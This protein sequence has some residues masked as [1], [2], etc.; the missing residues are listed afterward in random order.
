MTTAD[1]RSQTV[2]TAARTQD[3][4]LVAVNADAPSAGA[5]LW[6]CTEA[7]R[8]GLPLEIVVAVPDLPSGPTPSSIPA[9]LES[10]VDRLRHE[11]ELLPP[12]VRTGPPL[13]ILLDRANEHSRCLVLG[14]RDLGSV[15]RVIAGSMS[16]AVAGRSPVP[17]VV[18]PDRWVAVARGSHPVVA[19]VATTA[20]DSEIDGAVLR[21]AFE[22][23]DR[24]RVPL[25][26]THAWDVP[27]LLSWSPA[28]VE[29]SRARAE[30][31]L[32]VLLAPWR[33]EFAHVEVVARV[34]AGSPS[35]VLAE[36]AEV[37]QLVVVGR[38]TPAY[39]VGGFHLGSTARK[40]MHH[41][42]VPVLV[43]PVVD[44]AQRV[45]VPLGICAPMY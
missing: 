37:A 26:V 33:A 10:F 39:R 5:A 29:R 31:A 13:N 22:Q 27:A 17:V 6:A 28:D 4:I 18:V 23:A 3:R 38:H 1:T 19:G 43:V 15:Y 42:D 36:A 21:A 35:D 34:V 40:F 20:V 41:L 44:R 30:Q 32:D 24:L 16:I 45:Q 11:A 25:V 14:H 7:E 9:P 8:L 2:S 12:V